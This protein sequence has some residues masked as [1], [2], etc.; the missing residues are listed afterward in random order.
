M[1]ECHEEEWMSECRSRT[2]IVL[3]HLVDILF[4]GSHNPVYLFPPCYTVGLSIGRNRAESQ[5]EQRWSQR[6]IWIAVVISQSAL[7]WISLKW[8]MVSPSQGFL[9]L[10]NCTVENIWSAAASEP[11]KRT[12]VV[13]SLSPL[14]SVPKTRSTMRAEF[15]WCCD[16]WMVGDGLDGLVSLVAIPFWKVIPKAGRHEILEKEGSESVVLLETL[17]SGC[18]AYMNV[19]D[20]PNNNTLSWH[21]ADRTWGRRLTIIL[22]LEVSGKRSAD[23]PKDSLQWMETCVTWLFL[24]LFDI[25]DVFPQMMICWLINDCVLRSLGRSSEWRTAKGR[26]E[27]SPAFLLMQKEKNVARSLHQ[28]VLLDSKWCGRVLTER[29]RESETVPVWLYGSS[30]LGLWTQRT[31]GNRIKGKFA[32]PIS[33]STPPALFSCRKRGIEKTRSHSSF[34]YV[35]YTT[36]RRCENARWGERD[37]GDEVYAAW[38]KGMTRTRFFLF[39]ILDLMSEDFSSSSPLKVKVREESSRRKGRWG[40]KLFSAGCDGASSSWW[41]HWCWSSSADRSVIRG[42]SRR[43][44]DADIDWWNRTRE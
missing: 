11:S 38:T 25:Y 30:E 17:L 34:P 44:A 12:W 8:I 6:L 27:M 29:Q 19:Y 26:G 32:L 10:L 33:P 39:S 16:D 23:R 42:F 31:G 3:I 2:Y 22:S 14:D 37:G 35:F 18:S 40:K 43:R 41:L 7:I 13:L 4:F 9:G 28:A 1:S 5:K 20:S 36:R 21:A 15:W 24:I